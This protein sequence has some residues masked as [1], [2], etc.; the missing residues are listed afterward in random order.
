VVK[1]A[2]LERFMERFEP[3]R[4]RRR[5][6]ESEP[7]YV[8]SVLCRGAERA[9]AVTAPLVREVRAAVGIPNP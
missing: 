5:E 9:R 2:V 7:A 3:A 4:R 8:E 1:K 6:L